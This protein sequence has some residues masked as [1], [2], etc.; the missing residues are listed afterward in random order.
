MDVDLDVCV[1]TAYRYTERRGLPRRGKRLEVLR[2]E[3]YGGGY[4]WLVYLCVPIISED[5]IKPLDLLTKVFLSDIPVQDLIEL[6]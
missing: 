4:R 2:C 3:R 1:R 5:R 6:I